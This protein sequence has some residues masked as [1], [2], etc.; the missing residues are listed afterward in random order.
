MKLREHPLLKKHWPP[1]WRPFFG[2]TAPVAGEIGVLDEVRPSVLSDRCCFV[3]MDFLSR[4]LASM[5]IVF[6]GNLLISCDGRGESQSPGLLNLRFHSLKKF[7]SRRL[8]AQSVLFLLRAG[9]TW[10]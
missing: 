3:L 9:L 4:D 6:A 1:K 5:T 2:S 10:R 8:R 7:P